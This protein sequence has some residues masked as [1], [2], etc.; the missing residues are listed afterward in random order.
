MIANLFFWIALTLEVSYLVLFI[1]TI[2]S[3]S[4]RFWPPP[5]ARSWQFFVSWLVAGVVA[6][7]FLFLGLFDFDSFKF[8]SFLARVYLAL[9][10]FVLGIGVGTWRVG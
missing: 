7:C 3:K 5:S 6:V 9:P 8:P 10:F 4:F 2:R 1:W